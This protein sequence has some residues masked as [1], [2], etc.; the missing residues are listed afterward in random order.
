MFFIQS[1]FIKL[2]KDGWLATQLL[3]LS[4]GA[5][6]S[7]TAVGVQAFLTLCLLH[8]TEHIQASTVLHNNFLLLLFNECSMQEMLVRGR[9]C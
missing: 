8:G 7:H 5:A 6:H 4:H 3:G 2:E 1:G 9:G